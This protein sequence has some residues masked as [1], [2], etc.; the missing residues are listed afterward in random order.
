MEITVRRDQCRLDWV[1][2][3]RSVKSHEQGSQD[4]DADLDDT[5]LPGD[6]RR[7][8]ECSQ[9]FRRQHEQC[10]SSRCRDRDFHLDADLV[11]SNGWDGHC[12][13]RDQT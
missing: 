12:R 5:V 3:H 2:V 9:E 7:H 1:D 13:T 4:R 11:L 6:L 8:D 10:R